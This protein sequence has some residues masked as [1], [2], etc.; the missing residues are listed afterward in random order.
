MWPNNSNGLYDGVQCTLYE[1][2]WF[3][4]STYFFFSIWFGFGSVCSLSLNLINI[5]MGK[6]QWMACGHYDLMAIITERKQMIK[7]SSEKGRRGSLSQHTLG[8]GF[9][10]RSTNYFL[11]LFFFSAFLW[12]KLLVSLCRV[13]IIVVFD[14]RWGSINAD[15]R[16]RFMNTET[17]HQPKH[18][19]FIWNEWT[20]EWKSEWWNALWVRSDA[21]K[22]ISG[23]NVV[24]GSTL[25]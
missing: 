7:R 19:L 24:L 9:C 20:N 14:R 16:E 6:L 15:E 3:T 4:F 23:L 21:V 13:T 11:F 5:Y 8:F 17:T 1:C 25:L 10:C 12:A 22:R 18:K 2:S